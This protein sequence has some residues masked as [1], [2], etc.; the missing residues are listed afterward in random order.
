MS[1]KGFGGKVQACPRV[2]PLNPS[3]FSSERCY[4]SPRNLPI[5]E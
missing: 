2:L 4:F 5:E 3:E 1:M